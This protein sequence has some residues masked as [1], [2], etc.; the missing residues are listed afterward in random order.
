MIRTRRVYEPAAPDDGQRFLV[1]RIW[2]RGVR[3][4]DL[5]GVEWLK[6]VAPSNELRTWFGHDPARWPAFEQRYRAELASRPRALDPLL[7]AARQGDV[8]LLYGARDEEHNQA[9][10]LE[11]V[12][13]ERL[14]A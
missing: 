8:T 11:H 2:P 5:E 6:D 1:D 3:K 13:R 10:V 4:A 9:V 14:L 7:A 12:L